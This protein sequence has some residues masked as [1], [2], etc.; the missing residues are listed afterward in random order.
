MHELYQNTREEL[1]NIW[2]LG[3]AAVLSAAIG[4]ERELQHKSAGLRTNTLVGIGSALFMLISKSGFFDVLDQSIVLDPS[5]MAAQIVSG[6]GFVGG[7]IIFKQQNEIR[8]LTTA[9]AIWLSAAIGAACGAGLPILACITNVFYF[10]AVLICPFLWRS[11][12]GRFHARDEMGISTVI[13]YRNR[14]GGLQGLL[15]EIQEAGFEVRSVVRLERVDTRFRFS[16]VGDLSADVETAEDH[17]FDA[18]LT[19]HGMNS[20]TELFHVLSHLEYVISITVTTSQA[21][22]S[23]EV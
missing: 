23:G 9:A 15:Q 14:E 2:K 16:T 13:R 12:G 18:Y 8:G 4:L 5:R 17:I 21:N 22:L 10:V 3:L 20:L 11:L 7:G 1:I 19:V 6:I